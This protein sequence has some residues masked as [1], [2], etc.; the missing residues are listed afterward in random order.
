MPLLFC[1]W[2]SGKQLRETY[3]T[4]DGR[5]VGGECWSEEC[6]F[7]SLPNASPVAPKNGLRNPRSVRYESVDISTGSKA[8]VDNMFLLVLCWCVREM[9]CRILCCHDVF[10]FF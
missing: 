5:V 2:C 7:V 4:F 10:F 1:C 3:C 8:N 6:E 9:Y